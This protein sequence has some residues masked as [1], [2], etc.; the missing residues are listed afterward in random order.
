MWSP[1]SELHQKS[2]PVGAG[3]GGALHWVAPVSPTGASPCPPLPAPRKQRPPLLPCP[4]P[5]GKV[6]PQY[7]SPPPRR[8]APRAPLERHAQPLEKL[9]GTQGHDRRRKTQQNRGASLRHAPWKVSFPVCS[10]QAHPAPPKGALLPGS[11]SRDRRGPG[12]A[13]TRAEAPS[14]ARP[15]DPIVPPRAQVA[16]GPKPGDKVLAWNGGPGRNVR[17]SEL[18]G[19]IN[20]SGP[21]YPRDFED[22][23]R[24][25]EASGCG[26]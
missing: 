3:G 26:L 25:A 4:S 15:R 19:E 10:L 24:V 20:S 1:F 17:G 18:Q 21:L 6:L 7:L 9:S 8:P 5:P 22:W 2:H 11:G 23:D 13:D 12:R 16:P 14:S